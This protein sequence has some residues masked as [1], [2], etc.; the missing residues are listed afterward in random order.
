M[1]SVDWGFV[2][3]MAF[4]ALMIIGLGIVAF[5][6]IT[7]GLRLL[8]RRGF[9]NEALQRILSSAAKWLIIVVVVLVCLEQFGVPM[10]GVWSA[11]LA[12]AAMVAIGFV[13]V[14]SVLSNALCSVLLTVFRP[15]S[16]SDEIEI[17]ETA[18]GQGLRGKVTGFNVIY[19]VIE[20]TDAE[21]NRMVTQ[22]PNNLFF[23]KV[24]RRHS[25]GNAPTT[26]SGLLFP[27]RP[28]KTPEGK[29][30]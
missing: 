14:W 28:A 12:G 21:G 10:G 11:V 16:V 6:G 18:G 19:T 15:F 30:S 23:Q 27:N 1:D 24:V 7:H 25:R 3:G 4:R 5:L 26:L 8:G 2:L 22:I 9:L 17:I 29:E 13:A 20:E